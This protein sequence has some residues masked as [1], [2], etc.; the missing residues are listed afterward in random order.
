MG[1]NAG[2]GLADILKPHS[3]IGKASYRLSLWLLVRTEVLPLGRAVNGGC[4]CIS[5]L[6]SIIGH[7]FEWH[8]EPAHVE[9]KTFSFKGNVT[10]RL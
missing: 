9:V 6:S 2:G 1:K 5:N 4:N 8:A 7:L 10:D 3:E